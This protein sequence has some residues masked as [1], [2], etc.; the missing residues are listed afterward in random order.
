MGL[1][2]VDGVV[3][4][5]R[6]M[7]AT[8]HD[9]INRVHRP[10]AHQLGVRLPG[11]DAIDS[12]VGLVAEVI[13]NKWTVCCPDCRGV[14]YAWRDGPYLFMCASCFNGVVG[15]RWR[16]YTFPANY[17]EIEKVLQARPVPETRNWTKHETIA[18]LKIE[19]LEHGYPPAEVP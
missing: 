19:N 2:V 12:S 4:T 11:F 13:E 18:A 17:Q 14:E 6:R 7:G 1:L 5:S 3:G 15:H 9:L 16:A 10:R 8:F